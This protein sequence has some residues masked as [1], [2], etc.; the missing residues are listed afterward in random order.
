MSVA[1]SAPDPDDPVSSMGLTAP[2]LVIDPFT[3]SY[4]SPQPVSVVAKRDLDNLRL[5]YRL[6]GDR[7]VS[8]P[9]EEWTGGERYGDIND[10]YYA[11]FR[12]SVRGAMSGDS[13]KVWF[14][15]DKPGTGPVT[16]ERFTYTVSDDTGGDV[17]VLAA[18]DATGISPEE[19]GRRARYADD[20]SRALRRSG[21]TSDVYDV[22]RWRRTAPD[23][24][25]VLSHYDAVVWETGDDII[26]RETGQPDGTAAELALDLELVVRD[27]LNE[28]GKLL[29][30][31][32]YAGFAQAADGVY[33]YNPF[34]ERQGECTTYG[35]YP[36]L[37][38]VNDFQQY[39]LGAYTYLV[40]GGLDRN[41]DP[42]RLIGVQGAFDGFSGRLNGGTS[43]DNQDHVAGLVSTS[44]FLPRDQFPQF[45]SRAP[46]RAVR[47]SASPYEPH[48]GRHYM[49]SQ[50]ADIT[51]KRLTRTVSLR[52]ESRGRLRFQIS[53]DA[54]TDWDH[55]F[56]EAR[57]VGTR[58][59][60]TLPDQNGHTTRSTGESCKEG[61]VQALHPFLAHYMND[62]CQPRGSTGTWHAA[63]G[64]S[65]S[66]QPW[67]IDLS[68][69]AGKRVQLSITYA[70]DWGFQGL[71]VFVD[72]AHVTVGGDVVSRTSFE[73][74]L[75]GWK[76]PGAPPGSLRNIN[77]WSRSRTAVQ[78]GA[79]VSTDDTV[80]AGFGVEGLRTQA[81]R[82]GFVQ[83]A[84]TSLLG[85]AQ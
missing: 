41:G 50:Q 47:S 35:E 63:T 36:C 79:V 13:V 74:G 72:D 59:W 81:M 5:N 26:P 3:V 37:P 32:K 45:S 7:A 9:V 69:Y 19:P 70:S 27:Y 67:S 16:S 17:L 62:K 73:D 14:S 12:G 78:E 25:G 24:L 57:P 82:T 77:D 38:L 64:R 53:Y 60:T 8:S 80:Y 4:G 51:Y 46:V 52:G 39:W 65:N 10:D 18:E 43:A 48:R 34:E 33:Y 40:G 56:V 44:S 76:V 30:A 49:Y 42:F 23:A 54:E 6:N 71:G 11:E 61:W 55:V 21:Y 20:Y 31:G 84:M 75:D 58:R 85:G 15:A 28:G 83:R 1:K 66:W 22:D 29:L 2:D 68:R